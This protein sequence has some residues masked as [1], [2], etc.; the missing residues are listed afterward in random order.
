MKYRKATLAAVAV[1]VA[2]GLL[3]SVAQ[4]TGFQHFAA[5]REWGC[6]PVNQPNC[7]GG[8]GGNAAGLYGTVNLAT[9]YGFSITDGSW[10]DHE[11]W[12]FFKNGDWVEAG[13][14]VGGD[15]NGHE[16]TNPEMFWA[17]A[18]STT[19]Y[20]PFN[21]NGGSFSTDYKVD[22]YIDPDGYIIDVGGNQVDDDHQVGDT[23]SGMAAGVESDS[24][25]TQN[26]LESGTISSMGW[27]T[28]SGGKTSGWDG[29]SGGNHQAWDL[30][31]GND[32]GNFCSAWSTQ[33]TD[34]KDGIFS[35]C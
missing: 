18:N 22:I 4:A 31:Y 8:L 30:G 23:V 7:T 35:S 1:A 13:V 10:I 32:N 33:Y 14:Y 24:S 11:M 9:A 5:T 17:Y 34:L 29:I 27:Y 20:G 2:F 25:N 21:I 28:P 12:L 19:F 6:F 15:G 3:P 26:I 16:F